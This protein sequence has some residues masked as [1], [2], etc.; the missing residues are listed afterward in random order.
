MGVTVSSY[1]FLKYII[2]DNKKL[3]KTLTLGRQNDH[4]GWINPET[5]TIDK[6]CEPMLIN[7]FKAS[8]VESVDVSDY[9]KLL[10]FKT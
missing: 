4:F 7:E 10:I 9:E 3:E 1:N 5:G 6:Y 8:R 2:K